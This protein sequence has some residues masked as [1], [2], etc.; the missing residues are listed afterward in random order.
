MNGGGRRK[1]VRTIQD[2]PEYGERANCSKGN[3]V[4]CRKIVMLQNSE[5][6][7]SEPLIKTAAKSPDLDQA[8]ENAATR[9]D[10]ERV[11]KLVEEDGVVPTNRHMEAAK[12]MKE[13]RIASYLSSKIAELVDK[14]WDDL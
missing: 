1:G 13:H 6:S 5:P 14:R 9:G 10:F 7:L 4:D 11:K 12:L 8:L 2:L 3:A